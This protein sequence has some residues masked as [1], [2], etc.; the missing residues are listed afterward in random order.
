[1]ISCWFYDI[2]LQDGCIRFPFL[3]PI[4]MHL[5]GPQN[6]ML[7]FSS[8]VLSSVSMVRIHQTKLRQ[9]AGVT[10]ET[11]QQHWSWARNINQ[12]HFLKGLA[13]EHQPTIS[14]LSLIR[15]GFS[16]HSAWILVTFFASHGGVKLK[17]NRFTVPRVQRY[18]RKIIKRPHRVGNDGG[19]DFIEKNMLCKK[20]LS[21]DRFFPRG[22]WD[23]P[24]KS[25]KRNHRGLFFFWHQDPAVLKNQ[26][27]LKMFDGLTIQNAC[28]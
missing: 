15:F 5:Q 18:K 3:S 9:E 7:I 23:V 21:R 24:S 10:V 8:F 12:L 27:T 13:Q 16:H 25:L 26:M 14:S 17:G 4:F 1:M 22:F 6:V 28:P 19:S 20:S 11:P 2:V